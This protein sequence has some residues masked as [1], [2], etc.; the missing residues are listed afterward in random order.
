MYHFWPFRATVRQNISIPDDLKLFYMKVLI[1]IFLGWIFFPN[2]ARL[3]SKC[4]CV[5]CA[6]TRMEAP[7]ITS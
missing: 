6:R 5:T 2:V 4:I 1:D 7:G 3:R